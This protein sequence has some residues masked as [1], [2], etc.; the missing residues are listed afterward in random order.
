MLDPTVA[1]G[2][3]GL[4]GAIVLA[5]R[6]LAANGR[7]WR[8]APL[9]WLT[10]IGLALCTASIYAWAGVLTGSLVII[11]AGPTWALFGLWLIAWPTLL[12]GLRPGGSVPRGLGVGLATA[13]LLMV[14]LW[15]LW[16]AA[17]LG[18]GPN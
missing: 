10:G 14:A 7:A 3:A 13:V 15:A 16:G 12:A 11:D 5:L 6:A 17:I 18:R 2:I 9:P 1:L 4:C 8:W